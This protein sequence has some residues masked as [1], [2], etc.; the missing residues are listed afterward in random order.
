MPQPRSS[1]RE[2]AGICAATRPRSTRR[3]RAGRP[4]RALAANVDYLGAASEVV[5]CVRDV[6][7]PDLDLTRPR[8]P[9]DPER[10]AALADELNLGGSAERIVAA[11]AR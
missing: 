10:F 6:A 11:L 8:A 1:T 9:R 3:S 7:L 4:L 2:D 5:A